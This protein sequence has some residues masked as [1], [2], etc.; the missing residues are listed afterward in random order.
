MQKRALII[1][2]TSGLGF[3]IAKK[4]NH[5]YEV[6][7]TGRRSRGDILYPHQQH[8]LPLDADNLLDTLNSLFS[9]IKHIDLLVYAAGFFQ[10]GL[11][12]ELNR[13]SIEHMIHVGLSAP[14]I[15]L[16]KLLARQ[17]TLPG[18]IAITSTS[19]WTPRPNE[20]VYTA[21]KA[22]LGMLARSVSHDSHIQR[23]LVVA[24]AGMKT[25]FWRNTEQDTSTMLNPE[26]V[27]EQIM[28]LWE[29][30]YSYQYAKILRE[31]ARVEITEERL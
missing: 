14:A 17:R 26:W 7:I 27:A 3:E 15:A 29:T 21:V 11:I 6:H 2:G 9:K 8:Y 20:P 24:P 4:L 28:T 16:N 25:N 31:P 30:S 1:G 12:G 23:T 18:F 10:S 13:S 5:E 22:G 19:E